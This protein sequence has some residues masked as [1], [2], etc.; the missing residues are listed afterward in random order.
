ME[1]DLNFLSEQNKQFS[2]SNENLLFELEQQKNENAH[3]SQLVTLI[4]EKLTHTTAD[5]EN[6]IKITAQMQ[7]NQRHQSVA[8]LLLVRR[9]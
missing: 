6:E 7:E 4:E 3:K 9:T 5:L 8:P 2:E 1:A